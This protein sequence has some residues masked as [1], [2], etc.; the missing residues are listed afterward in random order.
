MESIHPI[1][2]YPHIIKPYACILQ[3][4]CHNIFISN[5]FSNFF[6]NM[7]NFETIKV[8]YVIMINKQSDPMSS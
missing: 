7:F 1:Q 4:I 5:E 3:N 8:C 6:R 2:K